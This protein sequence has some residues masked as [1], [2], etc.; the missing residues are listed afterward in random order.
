MFGLWEA[1]PRFTLSL[2]IVAVNGTPDCA[3]VNARDPPVTD[4]FRD[5]HYENG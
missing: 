3:V 5:G 4:H 1:T 2:L